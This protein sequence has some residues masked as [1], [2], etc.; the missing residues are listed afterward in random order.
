MAKE[1]GWGIELM[2]PCIQ[3]IFLAQ[4]QQG[5]GMVTVEAWFTRCMLVCSALLTGGTGGQIV[6]GD[7]T[8][9]CLLLRQERK[10]SGTL[11]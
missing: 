6:C 5:T 11:T 4:G 2:V 3:M 8:H 9:L 10:V 7:T 1:Q